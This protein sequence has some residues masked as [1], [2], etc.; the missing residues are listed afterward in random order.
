M[1]IPVSYLQWDKRW[2]N[3]MYSSSYNTKQTIGSSGCGPTCAAMVAVT[4]C[5]ISG[6]TPVE[7][8]AWST[9]NGYR[10]DNQGTLHSY[11]KPYLAQFGI[12]CT[13][14][15][16]SNL[17][18]MTTAKSKPYKD[19]LITN[20][21]NNKW[22]ICCM[23]K[24][25]WTGGGHYILAYGVNSNN[26]VLIRDPNSEEQKKTIA[27]MTTFLNQIKHYWLIDIPKDFND[28]EVEDLTKDETKALINEIL[29]IRKDIK[30]CPTDFQKDLQE[31]KDNGILK[32]DGVGE[33]NM[34]Y[35]CI[36][37]II[38]TKRQIEASK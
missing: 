14:I 13:Q 27:D 29:D 26:K 1:V 22:A 32:G 34:P 12:T 15:T 20:L 28:D 17:R 24:G 21:K 10:S 38:L 11:F 16:P 31:L 36:R 4:L 19:K 8:C 5:P 18:D 35:Q 30:D 3:I 37:T 23:G 25:L 6:V 33:I 7:A 2:K 9:K